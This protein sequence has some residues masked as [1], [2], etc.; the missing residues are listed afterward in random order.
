M[1]NFSFCVVNAAELLCNSSFLVFRHKNCFCEIASERSAKLKC[2]QQGRSINN[3]L[4]TVIFSSRLCKLFHDI[5]LA[6]CINPSLA[7][8]FRGKGEKWNVALKWVNFT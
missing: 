8:D 1:K 3:V 5:F 6:H 7:R 2:T 4:C